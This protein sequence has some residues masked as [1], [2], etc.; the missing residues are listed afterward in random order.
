[1]TVG[2]ALWGELARTTGLTLALL[3]AAGGALLGA[4]LTA[5]W[6]LRTAAG[7]DLNPSLHWPEPIVT[8]NVDSDAGPVMVLVEYR[9]DAKDR[10]AFLGAIEELASE[11][12]RDGA[13]AWDVFQDTADDTRFTETFFLESW[14]E[15][16][17][18]HHR[19]TNADRQVEQHLAK[20]FR[21]PPVVT[22]LGAAGN[23]R[24][25]PIN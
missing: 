15:H 22:H 25:S 10:E 5:R 11:R 20:F 19:V 23:E 17:R 7:L 6:K 16:L 24:R 18:Q 2:S 8:G 21:E 3:M 1:M 13:Y 9:I 12:R 4:P 14:I